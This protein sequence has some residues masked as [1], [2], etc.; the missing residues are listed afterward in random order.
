MRPYFRA[1][2]HQRKLDIPD[3]RPRGLLPEEKLIIS[4][5]PAARTT[6]RQQS[7]LQ[8]QQKSADERQWHQSLLEWQQTRAVKKAVCSLTGIC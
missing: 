1:R 5:V 4:S 6:E 3:G 8:W 7:L 2:V